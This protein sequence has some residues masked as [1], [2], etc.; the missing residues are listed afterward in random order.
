VKIPAGHVWLALVPK[1][2]QSVSAG[3]V[4]WHK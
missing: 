3:S 4:T 1:G 2:G